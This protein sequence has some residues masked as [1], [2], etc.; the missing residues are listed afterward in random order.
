[1]ADAVTSQTI[2]D[3]ERMAVMKFTNVSDGTGETAVVKVSVAALSKNA[4]GKACTGVTLERVHASINGMSVNIIW[5]ATTDVTGFI[6][7]PG[8]Y[9]FDFTKIQMWNNSSTGKT[10]D[11]LFTTI[12]AGASETYTVVLEMVKSY[13]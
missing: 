2:F 9:T 13:V 6:L 11:V 3:G 12:G 7:S 8:M 5:D 1:M 10:G 4:L